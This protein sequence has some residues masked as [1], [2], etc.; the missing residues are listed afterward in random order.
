MAEI[1][2]CGTPKRASTLQRKVQSTESYALVRSIKYKLMEF[3][4]SASTPV[5]TNH[6]HVVGGRTVRSETTPSRW[7]NPDALAVLTESAS[8]D[9]EQHLAGVRYQRDTPIVTAL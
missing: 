1:M 7:Q 8:D 9:L 3:V 5:A 4:C 6:E 2:F